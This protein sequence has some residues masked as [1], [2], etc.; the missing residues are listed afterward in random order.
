MTFEHALTIVYVLAIVGG[1]TGLMAALPNLSRPEIFFGVTLAADFRQ[2][3][4]ARRILRVYRLTTLL[5]GMVALAITAAAIASHK[6]ALIALLPFPMV[7]GPYGVYLWAHVRI[8]GYRVV[9]SLTREAPLTAEQPHLP[10]GL[11]AQAGPFIILA[12]SGAFL[13]W[14]WSL[15][16]DR[17]PVHWGVNG[18]PNE[19]IAK[20]PGA[21]GGMIGAA[22]LLCAFQLLIG[23]ATLR[24]SPRARTAGGGGREVSYR[25]VILLVLLGGEYL[26]AITGAFVPLMTAVPAGPSARMM[27]LTMVIVTLLVT[28][29]IFGG[30][31][32]AGL[33][34]RRS[35]PPPSPGETPAG[36]GMSDES[37]KWGIFY[38][39]RNDPAIFIPKRFGIG[40]TLNYGNAWAWVLTALMVVVIGTFIWLAG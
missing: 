40:Y 39:D 18:M 34:W 1:A 31:I 33:L 19:W 13:A 30:A 17:I 25:R 16:P 7:L 15:L 35:G 21:V 2:T 8:R 27:V 37:W 23:Y 12:L 38:V 5:C 22:A 20:T 29:A 10:G 14:R 11:P 3:S 9:P 4:E 24:W 28:L 32:Y 36:D 6:D 26:M